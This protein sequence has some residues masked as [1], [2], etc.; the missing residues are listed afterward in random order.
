MLFIGTALAIAGAAASAA[1]GLAGLAKKK[2]AEEAAKVAAD[3]YRAIVNADIV[4]QYSGLAAQTSA[5][6]RASEDITASAGEAMRATS[7][8]GA[9]SVIGGTGRVLEAEREAQLDLDVKKSEEES[10]ISEMQAQEQS[11]IEGVKRQGQM[12]L[13]AMELEGAQGAVQQGHEQMQAG[14]GGFAS[15]LGAAGAN[16][17]EE[18]KLYK[19]DETENDEDE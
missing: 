4:N 19:E 11:R 15:G 18:R 9:A 17:V 2:R 7:D 10:R 3:K 13:A 8:A 6:D 5:L 16:L 14:L 1:Q 12:G